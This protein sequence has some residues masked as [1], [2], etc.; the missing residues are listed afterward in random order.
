[1]K[2]YYSV[3]K[4]DSIFHYTL[5]LLGINESDTT[6]LNRATFIRSANTWYR[7]ADDWIWQAT[8]TWE[9]DDSNFDTLPI[10]TATLADNQQDYTIPSAARKLLRIEVK[11]S[12][13]DY[14]QIDPFDQSEIHQAMSEYM[15]EAGMPKG[16]DMIGRTIMLYPKPSTSYVTAS[17]GLKLY[18][19][20]DIDEFT[21][22]DTTKEPGFDNHYHCL[23]AYGSALDY[24]LANNLTEKVSYLS[25]L[26]KEVREDMGQFYAR[27]H[28][29]QRPRI[30]PKTRSSI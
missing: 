12:D 1:M 26:I 17:K 13:G 7:K 21:A 29:D 4:S 19:S 30:E 2:I 15:E 8:G 16:Y 10:A 5:S 22:S 11:N 18:L 14:I 3:D 28:T 20:R 23:I 25:S 6:T 9:F 24:A 27:R